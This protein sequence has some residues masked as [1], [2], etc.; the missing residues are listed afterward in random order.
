MNFKEIQQKVIKT[1]LDYGER[2]EVRIDKDF[3]VIKLFEEVGEFAQAI[4]IHNKKCRKSKLAPE[5]A[6][7]KEL[8]KELADVVGLAMLNAHLLDIDLEDA[9]DKKWINKEK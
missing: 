7:K 9:I 5:D 2:H 3:A 4:L 8:A 6:S 1:A